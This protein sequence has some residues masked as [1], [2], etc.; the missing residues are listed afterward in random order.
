MLLIILASHTIPAQQVTPAFYL[1]A[2]LEPK[3]IYPML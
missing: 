2:A 1:C 3:C